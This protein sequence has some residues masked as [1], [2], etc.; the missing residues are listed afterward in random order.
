MNTKCRRIF[1]AMI[2]HIVKLRDDCPSSFVKLTLYAVRPLLFNDYSLKILRLLC[3]DYENN[4]LIW[5]SFLAHLLYFGFSGY[6]ELMSGPMRP[7]T[8]LKVYEVDPDQCSLYEVVPNESLILKADVLCL[9]R[10][11]PATFSFVL[12]KWISFCMKESGSFVPKINRALIDLGTISCTVAN[13]ASI[14][15]SDNA[16]PT[17]IPQIAYDLGIISTSLGFISHLVYCFSRLSSRKQCL[18]YSPLFIIAF[19]VSFCMVFVPKIIFFAD[20][21]GAHSF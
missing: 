5:T 16:E 6:K 4:G 17:S 20:S 12:R 8:E 1:E 13:G 18:D 21:E 2:N 10:L 14:C 11:L 3:Y 7:F 19:F 15:R 9:A